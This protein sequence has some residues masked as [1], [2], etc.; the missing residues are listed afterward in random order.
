M[1]PAPVSAERPST[2]SVIAQRWRSQF[3]PSERESGHGDASGGYLFDRFYH[4]LQAYIAGQGFVVAAYLSCW[5]D[6]GCDNGRASFLQALKMIDHMM[7]PLSH[8]W[9]F[10]NHDIPR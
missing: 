9:L 2:R 4:E 7:N 1:P 10:V 5:F 8:T 6:A 3:S